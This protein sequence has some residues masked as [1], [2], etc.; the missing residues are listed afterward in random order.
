MKESLHFWEGKKLETYAYCVMP[1][2]VHWVFGL[3]E[4][5]KEGNPV[6]LQD[7]MHSVKKELCFQG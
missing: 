5:D 4:K 2:H 1:N 7:I 6:Y 3:F